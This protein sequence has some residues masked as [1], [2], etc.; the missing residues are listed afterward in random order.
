MN[1][2]FSMALTV[3]E[4]RRA[5]HSMRF[6]DSFLEI[7]TAVTGDDTFRAWRSAR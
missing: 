2:R 1:N 7:L 3:E 5:V 6:D 4:Y